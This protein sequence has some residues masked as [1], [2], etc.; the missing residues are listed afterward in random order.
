MA[1]ILLIVNSHPNESGLTIPASKQLSKVLSSMGHQVKVYK[2]PVENSELG[3]VIYP[4][5]RAIPQ[6][7]FENFKNGPDFVFDLH[8][9]PSDS[10]YWQHEGKNFDF[11]VSKHPIHKNSKVFLIEMRADYVDI[12]Q[13]ISA[14]ARIA[15]FEG[16]VSSRNP[17]YLLRSANLQKTI[18]SGIDVEY[19][20]KRIA[21]A[22][23]PVI[24]KQEFSGTYRHASGQR[25]YM[26]VGM[27]KKSK[28]KRVRK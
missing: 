28:V 16:R 7:S 17:D 10:G 24:K 15:M 5:G 23:V 22:I 6:K 11:S 1:N 21:K 14:T 25:N 20:A 3:K 4:S 26:F 13:K 27:K 9:T 8:S 12:P 2:E 19:L 18:K